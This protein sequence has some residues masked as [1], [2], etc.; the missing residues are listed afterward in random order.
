MTYRVLKNSTTADASD[1]NENFYHIAQGS[2]MPMGGNSL[3]STDSVYNLG[4]SAATWDNIHCQDVHSTSITSTDKGFWTRLTRVELSVASGEVSITNLNGDEDREYKIR[5]WAE[6]TGLP[7][8]TL[9]VNEVAAMTASNYQVS[10]IDTVV[11][12]TRRTDLTKWRLLHATSPGS[13]TEQGKA[14]MDLNIRAESGKARTSFMTIIWGCTLTT[15]NN[16]ANKVY[17]WDNSTINITSIQIG[18]TVDFP[19]GSI[20]ELWRRS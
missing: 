16:I 11:S 3:T 10:A 18:S 5:M 13:S 7:L 4:S 14:M 17:R 20:F 19:I 9:N 15:A 2:R 6:L 12:G 1:V 8:I